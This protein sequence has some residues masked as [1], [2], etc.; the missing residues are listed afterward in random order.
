MRRVPEQESNRR[1][2]HARPGWKAFSVHE[3]LVSS[4]QASSHE[5]RGGPGLGKGAWIPVRKR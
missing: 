4:V 3:V 1:P 5:D 2:P